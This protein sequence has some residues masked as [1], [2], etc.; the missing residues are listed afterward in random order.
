MTREYWLRTDRLG[1]SR[2]DPSDLSL[3]TALWGDP[4]VT[5]HIDSRERLP[6]TAVAERL[7]HEIAAE[8]E[9]GICYWPIFRLSTGSLAGCCGLRPRDAATGTLELGVHLLPE[10]WGQGLAQ[11]ASRAAIHRAFEA[12]GAA[13]LFAGHNPANRASARLLERLG[14]RHTHDE[15]Y[16]PTGLMHPSYQ[17]D[18]PRA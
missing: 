3:A 8:Q 1:F 2:W 16:P 13:H 18:R 12:L 5:Q 4:R 17:L 10:H 15:L 6:E 14:F 7:N 11:E 9:H